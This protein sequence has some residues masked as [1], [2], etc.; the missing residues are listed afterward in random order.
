MTIDVING[1]W[2]VHVTSFGKQIRM[3]LTN[4][5]LCHTH[6]YSLSLGGSSI[7]QRSMCYYVN[8]VNNST[9]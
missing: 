1:Q 5:A 4:E 3:R 9:I 2:A 8:Q 7:T 6:I